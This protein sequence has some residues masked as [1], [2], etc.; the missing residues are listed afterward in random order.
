M[1]SNVDPDVALAVLRRNWGDVD[2]AATALLE[3]DTG[4]APP[5]YGTF[6]PSLGQDDRNTIVG[7]RTPPPSKPERDSPPGVIDLTGDDDKD[8]SQALKASLEDHGT[9]FGPSNRAPDPNWAMVSSNAAIGPANEQAADVHNDD[10]RRAIEASLS[11]T[12]EMTIDTYD[13]LPL[14]QRVR[15]GD[16]PVT[17]RPTQASRVCAAL[18]THGLFFV[19]QVRY[20][21]S[22]YRPLPP[23]IDESEDEPIEILP[24]QE[25]IAYVVWSLVETFVNMDLARTTELNVDRALDAFDATLW[26]GAGEQPGDVAYHFYNKLAWAVETAMLED[27]DRDKDTRLFHF[28]YGLSDTDAPTGPLDKRSDMSVVKVAVRG[29]PDANDLLSCLSLE[30]SPIGDTGHHQVIFQPSEVV[31]FQLV[32]DGMLPSGSNHERRTFAFPNHVYLDQFLQENAKLASDKRRLQRELYAQ[33]DE[34]KERRRHLN[35]NEGRNV[36]ND[37]RSSIHYYEN[38][39]EHNDDETRKAHLQDMAT[40]LQA[41]LVRVEREIRILDDQIAKAQIS[42]ASVYDC[43]EL[44][45]HRYDLRVVLVHDGL[46]GRS[47]LYSYVKQRDK[48]WKIVDYS[49]LEVCS[50]CKYALV[51]L[52]TE[53]Q[54]SEET[55]LHD[56]IGLHLNAGP[57]FLIYSRAIPE[58]SL[59]PDWPENVKNSVKHNNA[60]FF[61]SLPPEVANDIEDPNSPP[62]SPMA[63]AVED[64]E[65]EGE[66]MDLSN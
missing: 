10:M 39:A 61:S 35:W 15:Q 7:P 5:P 36:L 37:L 28:R 20:W 24:P 41:I 11:M 48:W 42:A 57:F 27:L 12:N 53:G 60:L 40:K 54:V 1:D 30:L 34:L 47:H 23:Q 33:V 14:E 18:I 55:V 52:L 64:P 59:R 19:P 56:P 25:G 44:Q 17:L 6:P 8:L 3:G 2:K 26:S 43:P 66:P 46:Y 13:E 9:T 32:R 38:I 4:V 31:A 58:E 62:T 22:L 16:C 65:L 50:H 21:I 29:T 49:T 45:K 51:T 63:Y